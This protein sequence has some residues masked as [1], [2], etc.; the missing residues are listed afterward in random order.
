MGYQVVNG[1]PQF[2][3]LNGEQLD[4]GLIYIGEGG[5][6]PET[7]PVVAYWDEELTQPA[8]QPITTISGYP[9]KYGTPSKIYISDLYR[10]F[11]I[12]VKT[13]NLQVVYS[14]LNENTNI[15]SSSA[16]TIE[17]VNDFV[18]IPTIYKTAIVKDIDRGGTF[19]WS[20]TGTANG[21]TV[22]TG[23]SG[24]W[25]RQ[26][27]GAVNVKWFG[28]KGNGTGSDNLAI[29]TALDCYPTVF[30]P[31]GLYIIN[32]AIKNTR[33]STI[34]NYFNRPS[35]SVK[36]QETGVRIIGE[37]IE[38]TVLVEGASFIGDSII[39]LDGDYDNTSTPSVPTRQF[40]N[41]I[42][43]LTIKGKSSALS[44]AKG[45][46][47]KSVHTAKFRNVIFTQLQYGVYIDGSEVLGS[48]DANNSEFLS[49]EKCEFSENKIAG[50]SGIQTRQGCV[51]FTD[52]DVVRN[53]G[54]GILM[55]VAGLN[56][57][58]G[59]ISSNGR[60]GGNY[61]GLNISSAVRPSQNRA[62]S[63]VGTM[64]ENNNLAHIR[65]LDVA[66][67]NITSTTHQPYTN[68]GAT[69]LSI[70][71][72]GGG[73]FENSGGSFKENR[74]EAYGDSET[75]P[76]S[77]IKAISTAVSHK[78]L[79]EEGTSVHPSLV[80][81]PTLNLGASFKLSSKTLKPKILTNVLASRAVGT[82]YTN[83]SIDDMV[84]QLAGYAI[85]ASQYFNILID[86]KNVG[87]I[88]NGG[89]VTGTHYFMTE[90]TV[91]AGKTYQIVSSVGS[92]V[93][94]HWYETI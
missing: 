4:G 42:E 66:G 5:L 91:P 31:N 36:P 35:Y 11:S 19:I 1:I 88:G 43:N 7:N 44:N 84:L 15:T 13:K 75:A 94:S 47:L 73:T 69:E 55:S 62:V 34:T 22:F 79:F 54:D 17:T 76:L 46:K 78:G 90:I 20:E 32:E 87:F 6:N 67:Y 3:D 52:C 14:N 56:I 27:S 65:L 10:P 23:V 12:T 57:N 77:I 92:P 8:S 85:G 29:Q 49:F 82:V 60:D 80:Y 64:F 41:H 59:N 9:S 21:G 24:Y 74:I 50:Y 81:T 83:T 72:I 51:S 48:V 30:I 39:L 38:G 26:Y 68:Y 2:H 61:V 40:N 86:G 63:V 93:I 71:L 53:F 58:G 18:N 37:S 45:I 28:A 16:Y 25:N 89:S 70:L 33:K